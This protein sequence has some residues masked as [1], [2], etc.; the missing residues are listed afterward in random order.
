MSERIATI[1]KLPWVME[2][3]N[4][5][6]KKLQ[7]FQDVYNLAE[8]S[9]TT[10]HVDKIVSLKAFEEQQ[11]KLSGVNA[12]TIGASLIIKDPTEDIDSLK[13]LY[14]SMLS[15][16]AKI[17]YP[18]NREL[19][20]HFVRD[21][22]MSLSLE[23]RSYL[24][25]S[26][27]GLTLE[28]RSWLFSQMDSKAK[29]TLL[30]EELNTN[31]HNI[32]YKIPDRVHFLLK[33]SES[34]DYK[35]INGRRAL[36]SACSFLMTSIAVGLTY[37]HVVHGL[38]IGMLALGP[39]YGALILSSMVRF[40]FF[41]YDVVKYHKKIQSLE[42]KILS[43]KVQINEPWCLDEK[44]MAQHYGLT[45]T[46]YEDY[47]VFSEGSRGYNSIKQEILLYEQERERFQKNLLDAQAKRDQMGVDLVVTLVFSVIIVFVSSNAVGLSTALLVFSCYA[48]GKTI[49]SLAENISNSTV[50]KSVK[51]LAL[52]L[53][54]P[55]IPFAFALSRVLGMQQSVSLDRSTDQENMPLLS[56]EDEVP[57]EPKTLVHAMPLERDD[58]WFHI[59]SNVEKSFTLANS[60]IK[61]ST[62]SMSGSLSDDAEDLIRYFAFNR[63]EEQTLRDMVVQEFNLSSTKKLTLKEMSSL[64]ISISDL[65]KNLLKN[66]KD[67]ETS[68]S[69]GDK[70]FREKM[71]DKGF[72]IY[73]HLL[74]KDANNVGVHYGLEKDDIKTYMAYVTRPSLSDSLD[75]YEK[76]LCQ[77]H[78]ELNDRCTGFNRA[79]NASSIRSQD[80]TLNDD[81]ENNL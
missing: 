44:K 65:H 16:R 61:K 76:E 49:E 8:R 81:E 33:E 36:A 50:R 12:I 19:F 23:N 25:A 32:V 55:V 41:Q 72:D 59:S 66:P 67:L 46:S 22:F 51:T 74:L 27:S 54:L 11:K 20:D 39:V 63:D 73:N 40:A 6:R 70:P 15:E 9:V 47:P 48:T 58:L 3:E 37:A 64:L 57:I 75:E 62:A 17:I 7:R 79:N 21:A 80:Q 35:R 28:D 2:R 26:H 30:F 18:K 78:K 53:Q 24:L 5:W 60:A 42:K 10:H 68:V 77:S 31:S 38:E 14:L 13:K 29:K 1:N 56:K 69:L 43:S 45:R 52:L 34:F 4:Y 71:Q